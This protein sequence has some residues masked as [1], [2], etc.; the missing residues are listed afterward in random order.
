VGAGGASTDGVN[1]LP[2]VGLM[3][4]S[5]GDTGGATVVVVAVVVVVV[6][7][8]LDGVWLPPPPQAAVNPPIAMMAAA[9]A[10]AGRR[11]AKRL[12]LMMQS[13]LSPDLIDVQM[14]AQSLPGCCTNRPLD[15]PKL[16]GSSCPELAG[17]AW[18]PL[19]DG[20][21]S[22]FF[23]VLQ[24]T[25]PPPPWRFAHQRRIFR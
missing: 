4:F 11:R 14:I 6:V 7:V 19:L 3:V 1:W 20:V 13:Y 22:W 24:S 17:R 23:R 8:V 25:G 21:E 12:D 15:R 10:T 2:P 16:D 9:P 18:A 5:V